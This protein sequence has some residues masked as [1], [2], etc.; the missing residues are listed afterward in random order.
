[1]L[2]RL[3]YFGFICTLL[4]IASIPA[5]ADDAVTTTDRNQEPALT[6]NDQ[7][8]VP[9]NRRNRPILNN[10]NSFSRRPNNSN[11]IQGYGGP[12]VKHNDQRRLS[13]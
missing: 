5:F 1:M 9:V 3:M 12:L 10:D 8:Y 7:R 4:P 13:R 11:D 2:I 6:G